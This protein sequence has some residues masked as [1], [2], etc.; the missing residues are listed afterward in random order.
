MGLLPK[1]KIEQLKRDKR[2]A[3]AA[4]RL[5]K[6][7]RQLAVHFLI[8]CEGEK[9]EPNYFNELI[10]N[11]YSEVR[12]VDIRGEGLGTC[13]LVKKAIKIKEELDKK[14]IIPFDRVWVVFDKD[15]FNDFNEAIELC[16]RYNFYPAWSNQSF[17]LWYYLH[18]QLLETAI[19]RQDYINGLER[20]IKKHDGYESYQYMKN[21]PDTYK[22]LMEFGSEEKAKERAA[23]LRNIF[24]DNRDYSNH[25]PCTTVDLLV[26]ELRN[27]QSV[28]DEINNKK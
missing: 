2:L 20:E 25:N 6:P 24:M 18:F 14:R 22:L 12:K 1:S 4:K 28:L 10:K 19:N 23:H 13:A 26:T 16:K 27:P 11:T 9:T 15:D 7:S 5:A 8:V 17:E 21:A 3:K